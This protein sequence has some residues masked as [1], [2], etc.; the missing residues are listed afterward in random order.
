MHEGIDIFVKWLHLLNAP[1]LEYIPP[2]IDIHLGSNILDNE[3]H[4]A[5]AP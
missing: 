4:E 5:N 2:E 1:E 3:V